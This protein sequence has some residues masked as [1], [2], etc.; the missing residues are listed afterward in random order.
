MPLTLLPYIILRGEKMY[1]NQDNDFY[2]DI[3]MYRVNVG[4]PYWWWFF[5]PQGPWGPRPPGPW[6]PP[7]PPRPRPPHWNQPGPQPRPPRPRED[8]TFE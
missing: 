6:M 4:V 1:P 2:D 5:I 3:D 8:S 7:R